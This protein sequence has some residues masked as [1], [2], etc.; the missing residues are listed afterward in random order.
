MKAVLMVLAGAVAGLWGCRLGP[1]AAWATGAPARPI[2]PPAA[3]APWPW[4]DSLD[5]VVAAPQF[6]RVLFENDRVRV[7]EVTVGPTSASR[8]TPTAGRA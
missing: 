1:P 3:A 8:C 5:A 6:H 4:P 2:G 7:L